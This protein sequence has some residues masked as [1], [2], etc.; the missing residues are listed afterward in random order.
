MRGDAPAQAS[1][2]VARTERT[3]VDHAMVADRGRVGPADRVNGC[4]A[5]GR[6]DDAHGR[7]GITDADG[8]GWETRGRRGEAAAPEAPRRLRERAA[9]PERLV[10]VASWQSEASVALHEPR[11]VMVS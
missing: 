6:R 8:L 1:G 7:L 2:S 4:K 11:S 9:T 10:G 5:V 3:V